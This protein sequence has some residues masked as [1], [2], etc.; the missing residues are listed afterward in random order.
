[1]ST[2]GIYK[3]TNLIN[4]KKY[5]G[6]TNNWERRQKDH[7]RLAF[8]K[9]HKEENKT[10]YKAIRKY[11][12]EHFSFELIEKLEDYSIAGEKEK[13]WIKY[14]DSYKNGYNE[15]EGG[16]GGSSKGHCSGESNGRAK[17]TE[18]D[19]VIIRTMFKEGCAKR[20][21]YKLFKDKISL[22]GFTGVWSGKTWRNIMPE[23]Y[24][25][26]NIERNASLGKS[27]KKCRKYSKDEIIKIRQKKKEGMAAREA[28]KKYFNYINW[29]TFQDI[30]YNKHYKEIIV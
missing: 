7:K 3:I 14:Y 16:D 22:G 5:I 20:D 25:K 12:I 23:V 17:L 9:E 8:K 18:K 21:C 24:T 26:E 10:L 13:Y 28:H 1:M 4:G 19:V 2:Q 15:S 27:H 30:W 11:G 6:K 29:N